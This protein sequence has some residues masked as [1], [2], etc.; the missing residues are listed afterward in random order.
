MGVLHNVFWGRW[1]LSSLVAPPA[2]SWCLLLLPSHPFFL[3][4]I[5]V[6]STCCWNA[7]PLWACLLMV[8]P[9][10]LAS[11]LD[12]M[13]PFVSVSLHCLLLMNYCCST[14]W[15]GGSGWVLSPCCCLPPEISSSFRSNVSASTNHAFPVESLSAQCHSPQLSCFFFLLRLPSVIVLNWI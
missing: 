5:M 13:I 6:C 10:C 15:E 1:L 3:L 7:F 11:Q 2:S 9:K 14:Y 8:Q 4:D 12:A